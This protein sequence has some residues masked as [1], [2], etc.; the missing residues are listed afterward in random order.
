M[1]PA[2][3]MTR[4]CAVFPQLLPPYGM[5]AFTDAAPWQKVERGKMLSIGAGRT[6]CTPDD[7]ASMFWG[8]WWSKAG[9]VEYQ[10]KNVRRIAASNLVTCHGT[11]TQLARGAGT[12]PDDVPQAADAR[13]ASIQAIP[14]SRRCW[15][16]RA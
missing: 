14:V 12:T 7:T 6:V 15:W 8:C 2:L 10:L 13:A 9:L 5:Q 3:T 4:S 16:S 11:V 1:L